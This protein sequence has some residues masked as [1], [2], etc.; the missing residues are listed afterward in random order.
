MSPLGPEDPSRVL[1]AFAE[2]C[3]D[4]FASF[5]SQDSGCVSFGVEA[6]NR[7]WFIKGPS[8]DAAVDS[9]TSVVEF[10]ARVRHAVIVRPVEIVEVEGLP[11]LGY[12][13]VDGESLYP[14]T[15]QVS[16]SPV[17]EAADAPH[18]RF[19]QLPVDQIVYA[20][21][22]VYSAHVEIVR[23]GFVAVDFYD[24]CLLYDFARR[25]MRLIDLDEYRPGPVEVPAA[26]L[27][28]STRFRSPEEMTP[29][30]I[31]DERSTVYSLGRVA[32]VLLDEGDDEGRWRAS[33]ELA[34]VAERATQPDPADRYG[35]VTE[36]AG[37]WRAAASIAD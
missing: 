10:H 27:P 26:L 12:P 28:G 29:G 8:T 7:R 1:R 18:R 17:R 15:T 33:A 19:R 23:E 25:R 9:I 13:W 4:V 35:T 36:L 16:G 20:V 37:V 34:T 6:G 31:V 5:E 14:A 3:G 32:Q 30:A 22:A 21:D 2:S 24:G 11:V